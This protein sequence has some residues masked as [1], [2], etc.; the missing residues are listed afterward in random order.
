VA[1][2]GARR[3]IGSPRSSLIVRQR[4]VYCL[5]RNGRRSE[6]RRTKGADRCDAVRAKP[7]HSPDYGLPRVAS[8]FGLIF[9]KI[10]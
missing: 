8:G 7:K 2:Q 5:D 1:A 6:P 9:K 4:N 10:Y 3:G